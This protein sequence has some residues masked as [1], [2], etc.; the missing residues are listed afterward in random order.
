MNHWVNMQMA[1]GFIL[2]TGTVTKNYEESSSKAHASA[3]KKF[4]SHTGDDHHTTI[5]LSKLSRLAC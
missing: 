1:L 2:T 4:S 3:V 5:M